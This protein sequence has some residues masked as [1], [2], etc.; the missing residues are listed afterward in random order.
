[1]KVESK[2]LEKNIYEVLLEIPVEEME[3]FVV[4]AIKGLGR[5]I[6]IPG[7]RQGKAPIEM[8]RSKIGEDHIWQKAAELAIDQKYPE[9]IKNESLEPAGPPQ[10][11][12]QKLAPNNPL[13]VKLNI[14]LIPKVELGKYEKIKGKRNQIEIKEQEIDKTLEQ[15]RKMRLK[16]SRVSRAG[17]QGD[18]IETDLKLFLD[19]V[20]L[21]NG[22]MNGFS[23]V[24]GEDKYIP[25]LSKELIGAKENEEKTFSLDY[26]KDYYDK[27][28]A[29]KKIDFQAQIKGIFEQELPTVD[30]EFA[31]SLGA[32]NAEKLKENIKQSL[33][34]AAEN[35]E[36]QRFELELLKKLIEQ[37][38]FEDIPDILIEHESD[39][40]LLELKNG[41]QNQFLG[42]QDPN[43]VFQNYLTSIKKTEKELKDE[44]KP[45][46]TERIKT[47]LTIREIAK[48]E[49]INA[50]EEEINQELEKLSKMHTNNPELIKNLKTKA[51][52]DYLA[53]LLVNQ[54]VVAWLKKEDK[55]KIKHK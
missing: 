23:I 44:F 18:R 46:A 25:G 1:M 55:D 27:K 10:I 35:K 53:N 20:P 41:L 16:E 5:D 32:E 37:T 31:K 12:L 33:M 48:A 50:N 24:L 49:E 28:L 4:Q 8:L 54:K 34:K 40:M 36:E 15:L 19:K 17:K 45:K 51:G 47:A 38:K 11:E 21:D 39:K 42:K 14:P 22:Q 29:G 13:I 30:D 9:I 26:P 2:K 6:N 3:T 43:Q 52:Q 7:F